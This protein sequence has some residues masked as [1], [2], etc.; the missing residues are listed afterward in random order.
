[1]VKW[2]L[3]RMASKIVSEDTMDVAKVEPCSKEASVVELVSTCVPSYKVPTGTLAILF[4]SEVV[5]C[6]V[7]SRQLSH[8]GKHGSA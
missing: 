2:M 6:C 7:R 1:M 5:A 3:V 8:L 4:D